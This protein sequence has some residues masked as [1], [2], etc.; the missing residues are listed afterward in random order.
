MPSIERAENADRRAPTIRVRL[1]DPDGWDLRVERDGQVITTEHFTDWH[2]V[3]RR[4]ASL[5]ADMCR[6]AP[7]TCPM[8]GVSPHGPPTS[9]SDARAAVPFVP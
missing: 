3:E 9:I 7:R 6:P 8:P 5:E 2:R 1:A 4:R